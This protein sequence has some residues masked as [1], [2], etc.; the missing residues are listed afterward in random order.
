LVWGFVDKDR[1]NIRVLTLLILHGQQNVAIFWFCRKRLGCTRSSLEEGDASVLDDGPLQSLPVEELNS[2]E[3]EQENGLNT[4]S[5]VLILVRLSGPGQESSN[6]LSQLRGGGISSILILNH[7]VVELL[8]HTNLT[9]VEVGVVVHAVLNINTGRGL[10]VAGQ[11]GENV[12]LSRTSL[13]DK[14]QINGVGS[15]VSGTGG[16]LVGVGGRDMVSKLTG[17]V[18]H[19][20]LIIGTIL[21]LNIS[22]DGL[23]LLLS[24]GDVNQ[25]TVGDELFELKIAHSEIVS[26]KGQQERKRD[27]GTYVQRVAR[28]ANVLVD[29]KSTTDGHVVE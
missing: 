20:T 2:S 21:D 13:N 10:S 6:V 12:I 18:I 16:L 23:H 4:E 22:G 1:L 29:L 27:S 7:V 11:E 3:G 28:S 25:V 15:V 26:E 17:A 8:A 19:L 14:R 24:V 5:L 9:T